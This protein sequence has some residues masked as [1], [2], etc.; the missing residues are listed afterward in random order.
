MSETDTDRTWTKSVKQKLKD[1]KKLLANDSNLSVYFSASE[2]D[3][4]LTSVKKNKSP[5]Y[6][7]IF[8]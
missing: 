7:K 1:T 4:A 3:L 6:D 8:P 5:C 2:L